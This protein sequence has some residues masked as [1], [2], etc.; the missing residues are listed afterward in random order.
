MSV[1]AGP[2]IPTDGLIMCIDAANPRSYPGSGTTVFDQSGFGNNGTLIGS[3]APT[4]SNGVFQFNGSNRLAMS[5]VNLSVG[6]S[7]IV[8]AS[9]YSGATRGR[10]INSVNNNWLMGQWSNSVANYYA[11]D[12]VSGVGVGG[13][14]TLWRIYAATGDTVTD[15]W[16]LYINGVL[17][18]SNSNGVG[19]P[20]GLQVP[21][22]GE[23]SI[24]ECGFILAYNRVLS[25]SEIQQN[26]NALR[27]RFNI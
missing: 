27:G 2:E 13:S 4:I 7:T 23:Q 6:Q 10:M 16:S 19:G 24:G 18:V 26:F 5:S 15:T 3:P 12:W 25:A 17:S 20:N 1:Y 22:N 9:R 14:D 11:A 21:Q 8:G